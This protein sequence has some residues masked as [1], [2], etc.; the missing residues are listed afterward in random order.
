[1]RSDQKVNFDCQPE[2]VEGLFSHRKGGF[3]KLNLTSAILFGQPR[4][5]NPKLKGGLI[6]CF[7]SMNTARFWLFIFSLFSITETLAQKKVYDWQVI[8]YMP[9]DNDLSRFKE[10]ILAQFKDLN[11]KGNVCVTFQ[12]D[13]A[14][15]KGL[16]RH[17]INTK[18]DSLQ[19]NEEHSASANVFKEYLLWCGREFKARHYAI[20]LL[21]HGGLI[22]EY[23]VD[24]FPE[25]KWLGIDSLALSIKAF[26][27]SIGISKIDLLFEQVC[28]RGTIENFYEFRD[29]ARFTMASQS[30]V[31]LP[32]LYYANTMKLLDAGGVQSG[33][34][35]AD[36]IV[37]NERADMYYSYTLINNSHWKKWLSKW[38][39]YTQAIR[40][41]KLELKR[42]SLLSI[43][44]STDFYFDLD[45][46]L[47]A[48]H[49]NGQTPDTAKNLIP[50]TSHYLVEN[51]Y[52]N[53]K[54]DKMN[55]YSGISILSP[56]SN[57]SGELSLQKSA[58]YL[59][60]RNTLMRLKK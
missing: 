39:A 14:N 37:K 53:P 54:N 26:N 35:L 4:R 33:K 30:L 47:K 41:E 5:M 52:L 29:V 58:P 31:P 43:S 51:L 23:G 21:S 28:T 7:V 16:T 38:N 17:I 24:Q 20:V 15:D 48:I 6:N 11:L 2:P 46:L 40:K 8:Y 42:D 3:D 45:R 50:F 22:N 36:A 25:Q 49:I 10:P 18:W 13:Q 32:N 12:V 59:D 9:Y 19:I 55:G 44:Y 56:F 57:K 34:Q 60:F 27:Q 1:L